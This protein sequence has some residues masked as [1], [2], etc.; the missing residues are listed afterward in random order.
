VGVKGAQAGQQVF[1]QVAWRVRQCAALALRGTQGH[2]RPHGSASGIGEAAKARRSCRMRLPRGS[3]T[4]C[5]GANAAI[6]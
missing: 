6:Y 3:A 1:V 4:Y 5:G 2:R